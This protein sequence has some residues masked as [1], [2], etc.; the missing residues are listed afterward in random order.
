MLAC[1]RCHGIDHRSRQSQIWQI[2]KYGGFYIGRIFQ[3][4]SAP[5]GTFSSKKATRR[6]ARKR[7]IWARNWILQ[8]NALGACAGL[9]RE[10]DVEDVEGFCQYHRLDRDAF[11]KVLELVGKRH[12]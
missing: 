10:L 7:K 6:Q 5:L 9:I 12:R 8:R 3:R 11:R 1:S 4:R 2:D